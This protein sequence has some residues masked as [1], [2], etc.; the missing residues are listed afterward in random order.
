[1]IEPAKAAPA[2]GSWAPKGRRARLGASQRGTEAVANALQ[3]YADRGVFRGF[4]V[5]P[6]RTGSQEF[7]FN[8]L[9]RHPITLVHDP[10]KGVLTFRN[11]LP[12]AGRDPN[13]SRDLKAVVEDHAGEAVPAHRR[14]DQRKARLSC[15][16]RGG[17]FSIALT[18][19]GRNHEYAVQKGLNLVNA[20]FVLLHSTYPDYLVKYFDLPEE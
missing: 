2:R 1:M 5:H 14:V 17:H 12:D 7:R 15:W 16:V 19:R 18:V 13:L 8:W 4:S 10:R 9:V 11:L 6:G 20:V 3:H